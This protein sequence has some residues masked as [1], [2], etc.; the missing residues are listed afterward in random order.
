MPIYLNKWQCKRDN[1]DTTIYHISSIT[2]WQRYFQLFSRSFC[3]HT[4][5]L[6]LIETQNL[7]RLQNAKVLRLGA[8]RP[9]ASRPKRVAPKPNIAKISPFLG[10]AFQALLWRWSWMIILV[11][12][13]TIIFLLPQDITLSARMLLVYFQPSRV[14]GSL[15]LASKIY[16][17]KTQKSILLCHYK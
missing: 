16:N 2:I 17:S 14:F 3:L 9:S 6:K 7:S 13:S 12:A 4:L 1:R 10:M 15:D 5:L 8:S 11:I